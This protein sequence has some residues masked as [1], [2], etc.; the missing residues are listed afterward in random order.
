M[1][2]GEDARREPD[3]NLVLLHL[4]RRERNLVIVSLSEARARHAI[5][6]AL[7][8]AI[9]ENVQKHHVPV[10]VFGVARGPECGRELAG[11]LEGFRERL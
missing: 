7:G 9:G 5:L 1:T 2:G 3:V 10:G 4:P 11:H 6:H 8:V